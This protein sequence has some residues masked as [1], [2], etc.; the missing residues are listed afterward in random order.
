MAALAQAPVAI[1]LD[2]FPDGLKTTGQHAPLYDH[3]KSFEQFPK[4]IS[5]PTVWKAEEYRDA[6][7]KWTHQ[8]TAEEIAELSATADQFLANKIPLTGISKSNFPLPNLSK[9]LAELR[10]DLI[11]GKGFILFKGFPVQEW[12][13]HKSAVAY[14]GLGTYLGYFVSQNSRGHV[15][16]HVKDLGEDPTQ[17]DSVRIYRTNARQFF[18][19]DDSDIV[20]L[21]CIARALEGG[22]SDIV[23]SHHVYNT[24]A[25]ERPDVLKTLTEPIWYFDRKGETSKGQEEYIRTSVMY[26]ERGENP[27]VYTK[28]DPYYVRSL[29]RFSE[30]GIVPP[31]S[32]AQV[33]ALE[34]LEA[35]CNR[36]S[37]HMILEV[38]D[39]Q[40]LSNSHVLHARTAY[41]DHAPPTPRRHLMRLWLATPEHEGGWKLPFWDSNEKK[42]GGIQVDDQAP[43]APLDAE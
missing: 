2:V 13:N 14:M 20:G 40:F 41:T 17:I 24:L 10:A 25:K 4:E 12:G 27:R 18:H 8:F 26:L 23:S 3:I 5:G 1:P 11:D 29:S 9:R 28:W 35:T 38:G 30:A 19:A 31:L 32:A 34:V 21:L 7:E 22:E 43:V 36:L 37:L 39:I 16:G 6:P 33:E 15:L 42:R